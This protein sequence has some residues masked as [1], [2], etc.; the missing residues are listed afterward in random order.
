MI[1][2]AFG[3]IHAA[4]RALDAQLDP[5]SLDALDADDMN[6]AWRAAGQLSDTADALCHKLRA[7]YATRLARET[8]P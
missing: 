6:A 2:A 4:I 5:A 7:A 3:A 8:R 1:P